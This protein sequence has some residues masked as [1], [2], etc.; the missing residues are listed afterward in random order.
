MR[1]ITMNDTRSR[2]EKILSE[3]I[4][5][6]DGAMGSMLMRHEFEEAD[7]RGEPFRDHPHDLLRCYDVLSVSQPEIIADIHRAYLEAGADIIET[8]TFVS[9]AVQL[10][11]WGMQAHAVELNRAS[12]TL[13][14]RVADEMTRRTPDKPRFVA[15]SIGPTDKTASVSP[16]VNDPGFRTVTFDELVAAYGEQVEGLIAGGVDLLFPETSFDTLNLKACLFA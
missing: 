7:F 15:G 1:D 13:A 9:N 11:R 12:A 16:D 2:L 3:R 14:R 6:L 10:E 5:V 8:N 4:M